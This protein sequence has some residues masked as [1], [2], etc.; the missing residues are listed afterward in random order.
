[1]GFAISEDIDESV[2]GHSRFATGGENFGD[3]GV[4]VLRR[5]FRLRF[6]KIERVD[7]LHAVEAS[8]LAQPEFV[9]NGFRAALD[10]SPL[11]SLKDPTVVA[12][13]FV[14]LI[15]HKNAQWQSCGNGGK[16]QK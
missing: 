3:F 7:Q 5:G 8:F 13:S 11:A 15:V 2:H 14:L 16:C 4:V 6:S 1:M 10:H 12:R 9:Q